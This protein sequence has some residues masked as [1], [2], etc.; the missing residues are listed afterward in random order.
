[1]HIINYTEMT[2]WFSCC[3]FIVL[4]LDVK[5]RKSHPQVLK[6]LTWLALD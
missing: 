1:M 5:D 4:P 3:P 6:P 2:L